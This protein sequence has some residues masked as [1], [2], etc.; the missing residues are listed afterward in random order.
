MRRNTIVPL[1]PPNPNEFDIAT[2]IFIPVMLTIPMES[3]HIGPARAT[4]PALDFPDSL[5]RLRSEGHS[6]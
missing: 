2:S 1:V 5:V 3:A 6:E 4:D